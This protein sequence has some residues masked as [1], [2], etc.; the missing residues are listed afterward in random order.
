MVSA[1]LRNSRFFY[2][3]LLAT[4]VFEGIGLIVSYYFHEFNLLYI[5]WPLL[6]IAVLTAAGL[7]FKTLERRLWI[8]VVFALLSC[9]FL[10]S[11]DYAFTRVLEPHQ[12]TRI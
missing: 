2:I 11:V 9:F 1:Y 5:A 6:V 10:E 8:A 4:L 7:Y 3:S 12:R